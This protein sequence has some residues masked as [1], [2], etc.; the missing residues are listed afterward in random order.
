M[1]PENKEE[2]IIKRIYDVC[3]TPSEET[4]AGVSHLPY[5]SQLGPRDSR[6]RRLKA[7]YCNAEQYPNFD[8]LSLDLVDKLLTLNPAD[9]LSADEALEHPWFTTEP[10]PCE[11]D[12]LPKIEQELHEKVVRDQRHANNLAKK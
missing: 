3:G 8:E 9:R 4:W 5:Y 12:E 7:K 2:F 6:P 10:L 11:P 1:F